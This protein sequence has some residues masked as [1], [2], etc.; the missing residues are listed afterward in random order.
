MKLGQH[1]LGFIECAAV[2]AG[3]LLDETDAIGV[4]KIE[5]AV[6]VPVDV[7]GEVHDLIPQRVF[8]VQ[9]HRSVPM[10]LLDERPTAAA[11][12]DDDLVIIAFV[13]AVIIEFGVDVIGHDRR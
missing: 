3:H 7:I 5:Q 13:V 2:E 6:E 9:L 1:L 11:S 4:L 10:D 12:G 8:R